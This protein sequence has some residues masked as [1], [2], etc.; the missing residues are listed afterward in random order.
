MK[1]DNLGELLKAAQSGD[2]GALARLLTFL[3]RKGVEALNHPELLQSKRFAFRIGVTGPPGAGKSTLVGQW[4][5]SLR[6]EGLKVGVLAVDPSSPFSH[7]AVLGDR[8]R[9]TEHFNDPGVF[10][11]SLGTR[12]SLGGLS[13]A[14]YLMLRAF[15]ACSFDVVL[16]ETVGVGQ[17][18]LEIMHVADHVCVM[19][20][21]E[22]GDSIQAMKAGL[23]EIANSFVVNKADRPGADSLVKELETSIQLSGAQHKS[24]IFKT[25]ATQGEGLT[26]LAEYLEQERLGLKWQQNRRSVE[27]LRQ[28]AKC[29]LRQQVESV[30]LSQVAKIQNV[31]DFSQVVMHTHIQLKP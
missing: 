10:I 16:V 13:G 30:I 22:S 3:D 6:K 17:T 2:V 29:L 27:R 28:E 19:L 15:D 31:Q 14:A 20:V 9:Y 7:G 8:I 11:R 4:I 23:M 25:V 1:G 12:G 5:G 26:E 21:P 24:H 18:E